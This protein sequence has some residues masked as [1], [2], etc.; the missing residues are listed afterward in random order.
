MLYNF[1][2]MIKRE[3]LPE[4]PA[5]TAIEIVGSKWKLLILRSLMQSPHR[6]SQLKRSLPGISHKV[7]ASSL[8]SMEDD[9][10]I[11]R[12]VFPAKPS[13][14]E[15]SLSELGMSL[16]PLLMAMEDWGKFYKSQ[17]A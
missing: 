11:S 1:V 16:K 6:F 7:L 8:R 12:K 9:G 15:Y 2:I 5:S 3:N 4:C 13:K 14:V 10:I 17:F